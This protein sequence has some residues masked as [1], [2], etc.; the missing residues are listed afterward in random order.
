MFPITEPQ[1]GTPV[2][3]SNTGSKF[4]RSPLCTFV[5]LVVKGFGKSRQN[6]RMQICG[7]YHPELN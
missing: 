4:P 5:P 1:I 7:F 2:L 3:L 6:Y